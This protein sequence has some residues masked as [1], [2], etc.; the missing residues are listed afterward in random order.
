MPYPRQFISSLS[1]QV[2]E[3]LIEFYMTGKDVY[4][5]P[6]DI[7]EF[8]D[9]T[10]QEFLKDETGRAEIKNIYTTQLRMRRQK[11][12]RWRN[13]ARES[14]NIDITSKKNAFH[15]LLDQRNIISAI[16]FKSLYGS[17]DINKVIEKLLLE[18]DEWQSNSSSYLI[19]Y[20]LIST[21]TK[22]QLFKCLK[23]DLFINLVDIINKNFEGSIDTFIRRKPDALIDMPLFSPATYSIPLKE[24]LN[25]LTAGLFQSEDMEIDIS[26]PKNLEEPDSDLKKIKVLDPKDNQILLCLMNNIKSDF[27]DSKQVILEVGTIARELNPRPNAKHYEM[28]VTR[29]YNMSKIN[30]IYRTKEKNGTGIAFNI[31]DSIQIDKGPDG[32]RYCKATFGNVLADAIIKEKM[33]GV[34]LRNYNALE[35]DLSRLLYHALQR[36]RIRL[37]MTTPESKSDELLCKRY[38]FSFF[39]RTVLF[40]QKRKDKNIALIKQTLNEFQDKGIAIHHFIVQNNNFEIYYFPLSAD[41]KAD[42][43]MDYNANTAVSVLD[44]T[45]DSL[46]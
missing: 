20:P 18:I 7:N 8:I 39:Q 30:F 42:L 31:F 9:I 28:V 38:D 25:A 29:L 45:D 37:S 10:L 44:I 26:L 11:R 17:L 36:E 33:V 19:D 21:Q 27:Y 23:N 2:D 13:T 4:E 43:F 24:S 14:V 16:Q 41:E 34:T 12:T 6:A 35:L 46:T 32:H 1:T 5:F 3:H 15:Y 40:K 22:K